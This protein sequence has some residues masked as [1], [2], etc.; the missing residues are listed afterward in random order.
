MGK[1]HKRKEQSNKTVNL[2]VP[3]VWVFL[4][5]AE[6]LEQKV[7][8]CDIPSTTETQTAPDSVSGSR[9]SVGSTASRLLQSELSLPGGRTCRKNSNMFNTLVSGL[10]IGVTQLTRSHFFHIYTITQI[11][12]CT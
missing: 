10:Q 6:C 2:S 5:C 8:D 1:R 3:V 12:G 11:S 4:E 7:S 9:P